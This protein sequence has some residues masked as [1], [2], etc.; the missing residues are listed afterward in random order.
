MLIGVSWGKKKSERH[1]L[2][3]FD[4]GGRIILKWI[5][6]KQSDRAWNDLIWLRI[7]TKSGLL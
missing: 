7:G 4:T 1:N 3:K 5:L 2:E 6:K